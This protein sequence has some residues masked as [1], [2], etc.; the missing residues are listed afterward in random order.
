MKV[1]KYI[2]FIN[3]ILHNHGLNDKEKVEF[4]A[5]FNEL[6]LEVMLDDEGVVTNS[7]I[8]CNSEEP[9][10]KNGGIEVGDYVRNTEI[11]K[12]AI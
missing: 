3:K 2:E 5:T 11:N 7:N 4:V 12:T 9:P 1:K 8:E 10:Q 6:I